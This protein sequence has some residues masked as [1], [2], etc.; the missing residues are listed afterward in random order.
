[1][2]VPRYKSHE[3]SFALY[4]SATNCMSQWRQVGEGRGVG[5][6]TSPPRPPQT[7]KKLGNLEVSFDKNSYKDI[8]RNVWLELT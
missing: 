1:M 3:Y 8:S 2:V 7:K 6:I 5:V 4:T